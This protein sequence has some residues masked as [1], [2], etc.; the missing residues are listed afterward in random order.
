MSDDLHY[1]VYTIDLDGRNMPKLENVYQTE[2]DA[3]RA[4]NTICKMNNEKIKLHAHYKSVHDTIIDEDIV[5]EIVIGCTMDERPIKQCNIVPINE[6]IIIF[7]YADIGLDLKRYIKKDAPNLNVSY[8]DNSIQK[9]GTTKD[10]KVYS[11]EEAVKQFPHA[12]FLIASFYHAEQMKQQLIALNVNERQIVL[13]LPDEI[14]REARRKE[15]DF[16]CNPRDQFRFEININKHCNLKCKGCDHFAPVA[17]EDFMDLGVFEKDLARLSYLFNK[18]AW[19][20]HLLGGEPLLNPNII[21]YMELTRKYFPEAGIFIDTNGTL[22]VGMPDEFWQEC[23]ELKVGIMPTKYPIDVDYDALGELAH[24]HGVEYK[25]LGSSEA[26]RTLWHY[27]LDLEGKQ[28]PEESFMNCRN[29]NECITLESGRLYTC[30]IAPNIKA[31]NEYFHQHVDLT[32]GDGIDIYQANSAKE[33]LQVMAKPMPFCR[34]CDVKHRTYDHP[35]EISKKSIK[36][37]TL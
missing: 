12:L 35:W 28:N 26:G 30:S 32:E 33:I 37:W 24:S 1:A 14:V 22:L 27:P 16:R 11:V 9:Q 17:K 36:E 34:Y 5:T 6:K 2:V 20:I 13:N 18:K 29:A 10:D 31:F 19:Q 3:K 7:G 4:A 8:C 15:V 21:R 23:K 25:Y